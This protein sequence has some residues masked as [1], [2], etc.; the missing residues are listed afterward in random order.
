MNN[1][2]K[3][4][5]ILGYGCMSYP[6]SKQLKDQG[7]NLPEDDLEYFDRLKDALDCIEFHDF[8]TPT[9]HKKINER[10]HKYI[11]SRIQEWVKEQ[12]NETSK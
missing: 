1:K 8:T 5:F 9:E 4:K 10:I 11:V 6:I 2:I 3:D 12:R 7:L